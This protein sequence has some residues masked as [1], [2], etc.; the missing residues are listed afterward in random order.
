MKKLLSLLV[1][2]GLATLIACGPSAEEKAAKEKAKQDS[3]AAV[4][5]A[6]ED[7]IAAAQKAIEDSIAAAQ[8][9]YDDSV[10]AAQAAKPKGSGNKGGGKSGGGSTTQPDPT[11]VKAGQGKG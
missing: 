8:K 9:A 10:A 2:A 3:I 11:K 6:K 1:V 4:Q 5:K 7:S